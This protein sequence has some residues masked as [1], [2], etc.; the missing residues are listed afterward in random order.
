LPVIGLLR[1]AGIR[2]T[3][4]LLFA[5]YRLAGIRVNAIPLFARYT[6]KLAQDCRN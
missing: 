6:P 3:T 1:V 2:V 4:I 5:G